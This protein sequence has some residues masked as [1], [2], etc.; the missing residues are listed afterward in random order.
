MIV[1]LFDADGTL[2]SAAYGRGL[3]KYAMS[4]GRWP[5]VAAYFASLI[6]PSLPV[7]LRLTDNETLDRLK[8]SRMAWLLSGWDE[9]RGRRAF[10]W[11]NDEYLLPTRREHVIAR[12]RSH[13]QQGHTVVIASG[14]FSPS[15]QILGDRLGVHQ[16]IG[17]GIEVHNGRYTG[18][19]TSARHQGR[20][21]ACAHPGPAVHAGI[22]HRL[23]GQATR[24]AIRS[25]TA[26]SCSSWGIRSRCIRNITFVSM[27]W[28]RNGRSS[29]ASTRYRP[30]PPV[31]RPGEVVA[32][33]FCPGGVP[34]RGRD[35]SQDAAA[36]LAA[37]PRVAAGAR[38]GGRQ[39][40]L[41][42]QAPVPD[43]PC[44]SFPRNAARQS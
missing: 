24:M 23:G 36:V 28:R 13:Q 3:M 14:T 8:I 6:P 26:N 40:R 32:A 34:G 31:H 33:V 10:E 9:E 39:Q 44:G 1:A 19:R 11:V 18:P 38:F 20:G 17:T 37:P 30:S 42:S 7:K 22:A 25:A 29:K 12:L 35:L 21:Q 27:R 15:L 4:H 5:H 16:L 2:Y 43:D 41:T